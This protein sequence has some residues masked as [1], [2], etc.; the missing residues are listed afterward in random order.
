MRKF[1]YVKTTETSFQAP[2]AEDFKEI[3]KIYDALTQIE[4]KDLPVPYRDCMEVPESFWGWL[5][6][7]MRVES[8]IV[9][10]RASTLKYEKLGI[11]I[12]LLTRAELESG[13]KTFRKLLCRDIEIKTEELKALSKEVLALT[14]IGSWVEGV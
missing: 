13:I 5:T 4:C 2:T 7:T 11:E 10:L 9:Q 3:L 8:G 1:I 12:L 6:N 14:R